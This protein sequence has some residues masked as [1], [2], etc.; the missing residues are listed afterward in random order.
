MPNERP[1]RL[2][3]TDKALIDDHSSNATCKARFS[4]SPHGRENRFIGILKANKE[5]KVVSVINKVA[6]NAWD[7]AKG[8]ETVDEC[9]AY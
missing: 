1:G 2:P 7:Q 9:A 8:K 5:T 6:A 3:A 4:L